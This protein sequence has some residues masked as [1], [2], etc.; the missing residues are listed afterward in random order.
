[1]TATFAPEVIEAICTYMN[2]DPMESTLTIV[3]GLTGN[4]TVTKVTMLT[5]D[6]VGGTYLVESPTETKEI[7]IPWLREI[8]ERP[9]V[10]EQLFALLD[11]AMDSFGS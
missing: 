11:R 8:S 6:G 5:F 2:E 3:Q 10:R 7:S 4:R 9:E 1:M